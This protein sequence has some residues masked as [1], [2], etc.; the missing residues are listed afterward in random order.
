VRFSAENCIFNV[1]S[2]YPSKKPLIDDHLRDDLS[3]D[4]FENDER[5]EE[6][7][8]ENEPQQDLQEEKGAT[9]QMKSFFN[10]SNKNFFK[11]IPDELTNE[12]NTNPN[13]N[14]PYSFDNLNENNYYPNNNEYDTQD[15]LNN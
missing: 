14:D 13:P 15:T 1:S 7:D 2:E 11:L 6:E 10:T 12:T 5:D 9:N 3:E 8:E 4:E